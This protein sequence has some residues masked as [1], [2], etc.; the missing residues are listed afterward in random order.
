MKEVYRLLGVKPIRTSPYHPQTD[1][2][3]ERISG[4]L[5][6]MLR[7][8]A[9][10]DGKGGVSYCHTCCLPTGRYHRH[11]QGFH[12]LSCCLEDLREGHWTC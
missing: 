1:G 4:T 12:L 6:A 7:K 10:E 11:P 8:A 2:L 5:K 9:I 3:V